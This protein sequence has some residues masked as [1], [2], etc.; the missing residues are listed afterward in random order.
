MPELTEQEKIAK[1]VAEGYPDVDETCP[2]CEKVF[3]TI[4]IL[5]NVPMSCAL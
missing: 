2:T 1:A 3:K 5:L 4:I